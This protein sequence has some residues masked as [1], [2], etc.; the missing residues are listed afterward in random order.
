MPKNTYFLALIVLLIT[1]C[2]KEET[3]ECWGVVRTFTTK[4]FDW[5]GRPESTQIIDTTYQ[6][7]ITHKEL[8]T[9]CILNSKI[10]NIID[11]YG[12]KTNVSIDYRFFS[13]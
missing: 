9:Q 4:K 8:E 10:Y 13:K 7:G 12:D 6:C 1:S 11:Q 2:Q 3:I 5:Q